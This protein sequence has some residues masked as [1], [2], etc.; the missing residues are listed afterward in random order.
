MR[1]K[2]VYLAFLLITVLGL[3]GCAGS[4]D[5]DGIEYIENPPAK[6]L[7]SDAHYVEMVL[8]NSEV[9]TSYVRLSFTGNS[10]WRI[11]SKVNASDAYNDFGA[12]Q[13]LA[14]SLGETDPS[15]PEGIQCA[16]V[17]DVFTVTAPDQS[18]VEIN[19]DRFEM[20]FYTP[21]GRLASTVTNIRATDD[22]STITG[23]LEEGEAIYGT[24]ERFNSANQRGKQIEMF[25]KDIW[26]REDA[27]YM[28]IPLLSSSRGSGMFVNLYEHMTVDLGKERSDVWRIDVTKAQTD[29]YIY[30]TEEIPDVIT[31]YSELTGYAAL[32][33][34]WT[35]GMIVCAYTPDLSEKWSAQI[36]PGKDGRGEGVYEMIANMEAY[37]LPWTGV[38]VEAWGAYEP[39]KHKDLKELCDY[40]HSLGKKLLVYTRVGSADG[41]MDVDSTLSSDRVGYFSESYYLTQT[42]AD[43]VVSPKLPNTTAGTN[44]PDIGPNVRTFAYLDITNPTAVS[45]FFDEY[46][47]YLK[48]DIGVDGCKIDFCEMLPEN[49]KLNYYDKN[50]PTAG[51]HHWYPTAFCTMYFDMISQ[52][53]DSGMCYTRGGGIGAQRAP[54]M[55]AGDQ[56]RAF[57]SLPFQL[58]AVLSSGLSGVPYMSYDMSG[59]QYWGV[60]KTI[61]V[62]SH[63]F[64]RGAQFTAYT[65]CMQTHGAVKRSYQFADDPNYRYVTE[66][67]RAYT[68]LHEHLTP[69]ITELCREASTTGMPVMRHLVLQYRDDVNVHNLEDEY[70]FGDAFLLA[71]IL[72]ESFSRDIYLP[73]GSWVDLNTGEKHVVGESG[74]WIY[75]Y[76]ASLAELPTFYNVDSASEVARELVPGIMDIY[77]YAREL[78]PLEYA[79]A[80]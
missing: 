57:Y 50:M 36:T 66:I 74:K 18:R 73:K 72:D 31:A 40:V 5:A 58:T 3:F 34:E 67:Y 12:A 76:T 37:D 52:K 14:Y 70:T 56:P 43:G 16:Q 47:G 29:V 11:Q 44:N 22:G 65:I 2:V 26:G 45:W 41:G 25:T 69:Y 33:E 51:S 7:R 59:Y 48:N 1:L 15:K 32:P 10:G 78:L 35:Y 54:Y 63:V 23:V 42:R 55:W 39:S 21:S 80:S 4:G 13:R 60:D 53:P 24:G 6:I 8:Q 30:T 79:D 46:W 28:V 62:E 17:G 61:E 64:L 38:L 19:T 20:N 68:K 77:D 9:L 27:C 71:P 75:A 49:Y